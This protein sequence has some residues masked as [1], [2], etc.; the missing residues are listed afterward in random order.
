[1]IAL[2][3]LSYKKATMYISLLFFLN[4]MLGEYIIN[5]PIFSSSKY[6]LDSSQS[7]HLF[8]LNIFV[9]EKE[10]EGILKRGPIRN[11]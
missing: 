4:S 3:L 10:E 8:V 6:N 5:I 11:K 2:L 9:G 1:M 7:E